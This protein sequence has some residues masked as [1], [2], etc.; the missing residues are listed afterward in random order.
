LFAD[1]QH[2][3]N[4][5]TYFIG[6]ICF[7]ALYNISPVGNTYR[8]SNVTNQQAGYLQQLAWNTW[9][10][11]G[12]NDSGRGYVPTVVLQNVHAARSAIVKTAGPKLFIGPANVA[13]PGTWYT[14]SGA[15]ISASLVQRQTN[16]ISTCGVSVFVP[17]HEKFPSR[18]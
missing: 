10:E 16:K 5:A 3:T 14:I 7:S 4:C 1:Y 17:A 2:P 15:K 13:T 18:Q 11:Y 8:L 9:L 12:S 6:C